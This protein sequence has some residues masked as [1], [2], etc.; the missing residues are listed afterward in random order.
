MTA[1]ARARALACAG[2]LGFA[3]AI[4]SSTP[5]LFIGAGIALLGLVEASLMGTLFLRALPV[6]LIVPLIGVTLVEFA[7]IAGQLTL[8]V[9][10]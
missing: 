10:R 9:D 4:G 3:H 1:G 8:F 6:I 5:V 7:C 2:V